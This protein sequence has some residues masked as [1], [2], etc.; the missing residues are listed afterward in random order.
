VNKGLKF[1]L[2]IFLLGALSV[3][4]VAKQGTG[5]STGNEE[6]AEPIELLISAAASLAYVAEDLTELYKELAPEVTLTFTFGSS[7]ALQTQI[8]E[9]APADIFMSAALKQMDA[10]DEGGY[11]LDGTK[12]DL[13][14]N[15]VVLIVPQG[16]PAQ[17]ES[18][19]DLDLAKAKTVALGDP[20]SVPVGQY[21]EEILTHLGILDQVAAKANYGTDVTQVLTWVESGEVDCGLVYA[22]DAATSEQIEIIGEAPEGSHKKVIYPVAVLKESKNIEQAK[23]FVEFLSSDKAKAAFEAYGFSL[24]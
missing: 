21:S 6:G 2:I 17:I 3:G 22:T 9:G 19:E 8:E 5:G 18:F 11:L 7:G 20:A 16:N 12:Q 15:R 1:L 10:L 23:K 4:C 24:N 13:L 14:I